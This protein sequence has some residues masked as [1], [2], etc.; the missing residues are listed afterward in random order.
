MVHLVSSSIM[1]SAS[2]TVKN[3]LNGFSS[4]GGCFP[5]TIWLD[6]PVS[7][8]VCLCLCTCLVEAAEA[9]GVKDNG[10]ILKV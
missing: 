1:C 7:V 6:P 3:R 5:A 9:C 8:C 2:E 10:A 4:S